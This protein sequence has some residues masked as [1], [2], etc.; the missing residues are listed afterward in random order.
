MVNLCN[1]MYYIKKRK[2]KYVIYENER[3]IIQIMGSW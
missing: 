2:E 1:F 3:K